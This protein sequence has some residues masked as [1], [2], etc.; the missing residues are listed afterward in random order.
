MGASPITLFLHYLYRGVAQSGRALTRMSEVEGSNPSTPN[1]RDFYPPG[2][3]FSLLYLEL[4][5]MPGTAGHASPLLV[6]DDVD[7]LD[8]CQVLCGTKS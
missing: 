6:C 4:F 8:L 1:R 2:G 3:D 5:E 7:V